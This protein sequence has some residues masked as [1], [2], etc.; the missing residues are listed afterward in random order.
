VILRRFDRGDSPD[1]A[2]WRE[3]VTEPFNIRRLRRNSESAP[4]IWNAVLAA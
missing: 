3:L 2:E 1:T 4:A